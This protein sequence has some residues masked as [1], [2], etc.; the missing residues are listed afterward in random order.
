MTTTRKRYATPEES[1]LGR[2]E[3]LLW[4]GCLVWT[5]ARDSGGYGNIWADGRLMKAH[6]YAWTRENGPVPEGA[7]V[8]HICH[9]RSCVEVSHLRLATR[10]QNTRNRAGA[11]R[12]RKQDLPRGV[13]RRGGSYQARVMIN[14]RAINAGSFPTIERAEI[15]VKNCRAF[16]FGE[17]AGN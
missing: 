4:S 16:Y 11:Q 17:Y 7:E 14:G 13:T 2:T 15:A 1:F 6:R 5:G 3:P 8:D 10:Q 12:G 9:E